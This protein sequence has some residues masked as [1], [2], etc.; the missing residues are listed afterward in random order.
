MQ[1]LIDTHI[2]I[3]FLEGNK[4]L[5]KSRRQIIANPQNDIFVSIAS[6]WE[7][8]IKISLGKLTLAKPLADV[9]KQIAVENIEILSIAPEHTL[10]VS[11]L[12]FHHRDPFDRI[13]ISQAQVENLPIMTNDAE[14]SN[15]IIKIL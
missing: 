13:I 6:L 15:Y 3:W 10:Q 14:F 1:L 5:V 4:L 11:A 7:I 2:L 12:P 8:A 9:I